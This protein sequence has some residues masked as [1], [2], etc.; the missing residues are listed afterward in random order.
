M[1]DTLQDLLDADKK[2]EDELRKILQRESSKYKSEDQVLINQICED[3]FISLCLKENE[4]MCLQRLKRQE[5]FLNRYKEKIKDIVLSDKMSEMLSGGMNGNWSFR[6][7]GNH[8][9]QLNFKLQRSRTLDEKL[10]KEIYEC[11]RIIHSMNLKLQDMIKEGI[12]FY[13]AHDKKILNLKQLLDEKNKKDS[14][15]I[16]ENY[17]VERMG[18]LTDDIVQRLQDSHISIVDVESYVEL[19]RYIEEEIKKSEREAER[20]IENIKRIEALS[21]IVFGRNIL[22][23]NI[24][25]F[26]IPYRIYYLRSCKLHFFKHANDVDISYETKNKLL[27]DNPSMKKVEGELVLYDYD[28]DIFEKDLRKEILHLMTASS[29]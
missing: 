6:K 22:G 29:K 12:V 24:T 25:D 17:V 3:L 14:M 7:I 10:W 15:K 4:I 13:N 8:F 9:H 16:F 20:G 18:F 23:K 2:F 28:M 27:H 11:L 1:D 21:H 26:S 5:I 19:K